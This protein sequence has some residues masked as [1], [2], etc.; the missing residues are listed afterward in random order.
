MARCCHGSQ[1]SAIALCSHLPQ[2]FATVLRMGIKHA[3]AV[4]IRRLTKEA[5]EK[6]ARRPAYVSGQQKGKPVGLRTIRNAMKPEHKEMPSTALIEAL[7][8][9]FNV[10]PAELIVD[11]EADRAKLIDR[12][13]ERRTMDI[14]RPA[15]KPAPS[16]PQ[17]PAGK[18]H[19]E[20]IGR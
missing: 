4:N 3:I 14:Q 11:W 15:A 18:V 7:A 10:I 8:D 5:P 9:Y 16:A 12:I 6:W 1:N 19:P 13:V 2:S 17:I 20:E